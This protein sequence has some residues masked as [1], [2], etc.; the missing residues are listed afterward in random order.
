MAHPL[1]A[2]VRVAP[3][4][5]G[6]G[7]PGCASDASRAPR[8]LVP[9]TSTS[10]R[11]TPTT[12][13]ASTSASTSRGTTGAPASTASCW[14]TTDTT[15]W[16]SATAASRRFSAP[17]R[18]VGAWE[19]LLCFG[20]SFVLVCRGCQ[21]ETAQTGWGWGGGSANRNLFP[22]SSGGQRSKVKVF[23]ALLFSEASQFDSQI[24]T[25]VR[26]VHTAI[27]PCVHVFGVFLSAV[28]ASSEDTSHIGAEPIP[29]GF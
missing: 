9:Q 5:R 27:S 19:G 6:E 3:A 10:A 24:A 25:L 12:G 29:A 2:H 1:A 15:A 7:T 14:P 11:M 26:G 17:A 21:T 22:H 20:W 28:I 23:A 13:A 4:V 18:G 8:S 16:V